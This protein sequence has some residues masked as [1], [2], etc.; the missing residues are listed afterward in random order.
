[1]ISKSFPSNLIITIPIVSCWRGSYSATP[2]INASISDRSGIHVRPKV[3]PHLLWIIFPLIIACYS[4]DIHCIICFTPSTSVFFQTLD[5]ATC[6]TWTS[7]P[8][9]IP[10][11]SSSVFL[12]LFGSLLLWSCSALEL[13]SCIWYLTHEED[14]SSYNSTRSCSRR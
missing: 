4:P 10:F 1:V 6:C 3:A 12:Y 8:S 5:F 2:R 9:S 13:M 11:Q 14:D 7:R